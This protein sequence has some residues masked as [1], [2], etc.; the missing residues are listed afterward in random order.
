M[1]ANDELP[2]IDRLLA[3]K[4]NDLSL[5]AWALKAGVS[6]T[7]F[8]DIRKRNNVRHDTL[9][10][11]L[12]AAE[13]NLA[14]FEAGSPLARSEVAPTGLTEQEA[15]AGLGDPLARLKAVPLVGTAMG[16]SFDLDEHVELTEL[17]M[18]EVLDH[19]ARPA[20]LATDARAYAVTIVG[21]SMAPRFEPGERAFAS[22]RQGAGIGDD[23]IVQLRA[24]IKGDLQDEDHANRITMVLI[25][26]LVKRSARELTLRQFNPDTTFTVPI[27][28]VAAIHKVVGRL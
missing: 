19:I 4:P 16:G 5:N 28:R 22:P 23:V 7:V 6:R 27:E 8:N 25:K 24:A 21:D 18:G 13:V 14:Q 9:R 2:L 15:I 12:A 17:V 1:A 10:K 26:R 20:H 3:I 11:L